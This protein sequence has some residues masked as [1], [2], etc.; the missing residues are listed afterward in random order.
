M[1]RSRS[2]NPVLGRCNKAFKRGL[3]PRSLPSSEYS[4]G[5]SLRSFEYI[6]A[7]KRSGP[8]P[9]EHV[10]VQL[11]QAIKQRGQCFVIVRL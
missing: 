10:G 11:G 3:S 5:L 9:A 2:Q 6:R 8:P 7:T 1:E 4:E